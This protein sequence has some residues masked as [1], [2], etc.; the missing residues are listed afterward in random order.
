MKKIK[1]FCIPYAGGSS[2]V[3]RKW[4][5]NLNSNIELIPLE[6]NGRGE[7]FDRDY[8]LNFNELLEDLYGRISNLIDDETE[9]M[10]FGHSMGAYVTYFLESMIESRLLKKAKCIFVSGREA[11]KFWKDTK[12]NISMLSDKEF[13]EKIITY[14]GMQEEILREK[15]LLDIFLPILK[16]DFRII[17]TINYNNCNKILNCKIVAMN[18]IKDKLIKDNIEEWGKFTTKSFESKYYDGAHFYIN[19]YWHEIVKK[20]NKECK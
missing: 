3:Y 10:M 16:N 20:I 17:E 11:P 4:N 13:L 8:Y 2:S 7:L 19:D 9:F 5:K 6:F 15:E 12:K 1:I 18:G 14:G